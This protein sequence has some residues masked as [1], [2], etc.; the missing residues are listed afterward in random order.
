MRKNLLLALLFLFTA[1]ATFAQVTTSSITGLVKDSKEP[2]IGATVKATFVPSGTVYA[3]STRADGRFSIPNMRSGGP[4][5]VEITYLGY[6]PQRFNDVTLTLGEPFVLNATLTQAGNVLKEVSVVATNPR[7]ILNSDRSGSVTNISTRE[8]LSLPSIDRNINDLL[9]TTPQA[10]SNGQ[11]IGGGNFRQNNITIDGGN[12]NN[13]FGI[14]GNLPGNNSTPIPLDALEEISVSINPTDVRQ[15]NFIGA[16]INATTRSGTNSF[17]GS[18][19][20]YFRNQNQVGTR[21]RS[22]PELVPAAQDVKTYGFRL[23]GPIIKN[24]LFFF[25]N[26]ETS[27]QPAGTTTLRASTPENPFPATPNVNRPTAT[28]LNEISQYLKDTYNYETGP[29]QEYGYESTRNNIV[30]RIDWNINDKNRFNVRYS[31]LESKTPSF[32]SNSTNPLVAPPGG[33]GSVYP[34]NGSRTDNNA[35]AFANSNYFTN[36]NFYS[37]SAELNSSL[38]GS[39]F[40]NTLRFT[41][42]NQNEPRSSESAL[43]PFVDILKD[44]RPFT[45]FGYEPFTYGNLRDVNAYSFVDY[46]QWTEGKHN[47]L[48]GVQADFTT[49]KNGFQ[50]Y[51]TSYYIFNSFD[52]FRNGVKPLAYA[53]TFSLTPGYAQAFPTFKNQQYSVY[54][55]DNFNVNDKLRL[56]LGI[57]ANLYGYTQDGIT[58]PLVAGLAFANGETL[59]TGKLPTSALVISPRF[60]FNYDVRGDR[61]LQLRGSAGIF[62]GGIPGVWIVSQVGDAGMLQFSQ[63]IQNQ[64]DTPGPFNP[65]INAYLPA[66][67]PAAGTAIPSAIS[68]ISPDIK[69]PQTFKASLAGDIK[70]PYGFIGTIEGLYNRDFRTVKFRNPNLVDPQNLNVTGY[71]DNRLIYPNATA[72][73]YINKL[74]VAGKPYTS[75]STGAQQSFNAYVLDNASQGY[76]WS[77]AGT[78]QKQ[79]SKGFSTSLSYIYSKAKSL[80]DGGGDQPSGA[81]LG[82][83]SVN[84]SN[85]VEMGYAGFVVPSRIVAKLTYRKEYLKHLGTSITLFYNGSS[86]GRV[87]Y[88]YSGDL[89]RDGANADL[90]YVPK[91]PSEITFTP[92]TAGTAPNAVTY[93]AQQ[94]SDIFFRFLEQDPY[95][96]SRKGKYAERNGGL[97]PWFNQVDVQFEQDI[98]HNI[99]GK[100]NTLQFNVSIENLANFISKDWGVRRTITQSQVLVPTNQ[101]SLTPG[102]T[103]R[104]TFRLQFDGT[105]PTNAVLTRDIVSFAST[106]RMQFGLRYI[107]N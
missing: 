38:F 71:P 9:R 75:T 60:G 19:Y 96:L 16:A 5:L 62:S 72:D 33:N 11:S 52:D 92:F 87:S 36:Y 59:N 51:G 94:Q 84:G 27:K 95:L 73:K 30:A 31:R 22:Y 45:S 91:D 21:V 57:R 17:S 77:V 4:Y 8:V 78:L 7:S 20:T 102:G 67:A 70:L 34:V 3:T 28:E 65:D 88:T 48:A 39:R 47:L 79:F 14:G 69:A 32:L 6:E 83:T 63:I 12:F 53:R 101:A 100:R 93:S 29:Y 41:Y 98:F 44:G 105:L 64:A 13:A 23:G 56:S 55:Q 103:T 97:L 37:L 99:G 86:Q 61:S 76:Y 24:K 81:W 80:Y 58:H 50:R 42:N 26:Y 74:D 66:T 2:L 25:V 40:A 18:A 46:V 54:A 35:L 1:T 90:I 15:N 107:F 85:N 104:P 68:L 43:F 89:N 106:Y 82:T 49:T 10:S